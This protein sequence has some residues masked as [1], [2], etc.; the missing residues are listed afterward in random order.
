MKIGKTQREILPIGVELNSRCVRLLQLRR[1]KGLLSVVDGASMPL[2][3]GDG[4]LASPAYSHQLR[5]CVRAMLSDHRFRGKACQVSIDE[6]LVKVR[7]VRQPRMPD[8][9]MNQAVCIEA[10]D[11]LGV[12]PSTPMQIDWLR[13]GEV[14]HGDEIREEVLLV[15][16]ERSPLEK[17]VDE[18]ISCGLSPMGVEPSF[19]ATGR[20]FIRMY[21]RASYRA[22]VR[23]VLH[24]G[25][26]SSRVLVLAGPDVVFYKRIEI[27]GAEFSEIA[28]ERMGLDIETIDGL[29]HQRMIAQLH[30]DVPRAE[31]KVDRAIYT[32]VR[33]HLSALA[34][35]ISRCAR[36]F[37][38]T[39]CSPRPALAL[40]VGEHSAEPGLVQI[41]SDAIGLE[42]SIGD[43]FDGIAMPSPCPVALQQITTSW[44]A[45]IGL[46]LRGRRQ[47]KRRRAA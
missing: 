38:V 17:L 45:A 29:R 2:E 40:V 39:F 8:D 44:S 3:I 43:P 23:M 4:G 18:L 28:A 31:E 32:A 27:G 35:E 30:E 9:E 46:C 41:I 5:Q 22:T 24:V 1:D 19:I 7:S 34:E 21:Q 16:C 25:N 42:T 33:P 37:A 12:D 15:G 13:A 20:T 47:L 10:P 14:R 6:S 36:Y 26:R 11:R